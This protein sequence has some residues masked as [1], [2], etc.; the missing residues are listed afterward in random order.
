MTELSP[1]LLEY[2]SKLPPGALEEMF[3]PYEAEDGLLRQQHEM[4]ERLMGG[5]GEGRSTPVGAALGGIAGILGNTVGASR[6]QEAMQG[7]QALLSRMQKEG[8]GRV[9]GYA[10]HAQG[11]KMAAGMPDMLMRA[12]PKPQD[13]LMET[14]ADDEMLRMIMGG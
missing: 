4:A 5:S 3:A 7:R 8:A 2:L 9:G 13:E 10:R 14:A 12:L 11:Q 6:Q 1:E